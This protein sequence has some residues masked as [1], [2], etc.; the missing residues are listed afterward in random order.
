[1]HLQEKSSRSYMFYLFLR[2]HFFMSI[3]LKAPRSYGDTDR[4]TRFADSAR[5]SALKEDGSG[6]QE[7]LFIRLFCEY[8]ES[9]SL[10]KF[11]RKCACFV[12]VSVSRGVEV[13][14]QDS[15]F[16]DIS[17]TRNNHIVSTF[18]TSAPQTTMNI[19]TRSSPRAES[20]SRGFRP[21]MTDA[22]R[23]S[24]LLYQA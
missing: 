21:G 15:S 8:M 4:S 11:V 3:L 16:H 12:V 24:A 18:P 19:T 23:W 6:Q 10:W 14:C 9:F 20:E 5:W 7:R 1:M 2:Q 13:W 17:I 22:A